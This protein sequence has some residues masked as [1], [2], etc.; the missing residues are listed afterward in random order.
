MLRG[1]GQRGLGW[2]RRR[3]WRGPAGRRVGLR[4]VERLS[5][6]QRLGER[7]QM[8]PVLGEDPDRLVVPRRPFA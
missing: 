3:L 1:A 7:I 4:L 8:L 5:P 6:H 2:S